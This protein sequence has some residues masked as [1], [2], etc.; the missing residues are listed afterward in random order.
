MNMAKG[1]VKS[2][3]FHSISPLHKIRLN[4]RAYEYSSGTPD[5]DE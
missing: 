3:Q 4:F 1:S 5:H 2:I